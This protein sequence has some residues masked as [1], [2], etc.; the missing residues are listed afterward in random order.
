MDNRLKEVAKYDIRQE[1]QMTLS[2]RCSTK[3][4]LMSRVILAF[5]LLCPIYVTTLAKEDQLVPKPNET[6]SDDQ[7]MEDK[8]SVQGEALRDSYVQ[9]ETIRHTFFSPDAICREATLTVMNKS[10]AEEATLVYY[11]T[12]PYDRV[13]GQFVIE[14]STSGFT[15]GLYEFIIWFKGVMEPR[16]GRV[17]IIAP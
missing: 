8:A 2:N 11:D 14:L 1:S 6:L 15:P 5:V 12:I 9:G 10:P 4:R 3:S 16:R 7:A 13:T 17:E